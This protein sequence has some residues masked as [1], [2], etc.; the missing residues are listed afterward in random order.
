MVLFVEYVILFFFMMVML[1]VLLLIFII[2][3]LFSCSRFV[4]VVGLF[5]IWFIFSL[6][7]FSMLM[8]ICGFV[9]GGNEVVVWLK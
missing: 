4:I 8:E 6:V 9:S 2:L 7:D 3:V 1:V 5:S